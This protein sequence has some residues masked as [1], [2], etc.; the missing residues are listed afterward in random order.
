M[1]FDPLPIPGAYLVRLSPYKDERGEFS[2]IYCANEFRIPY[3]N[4]PLL[5]INHS[6][7]RER[8]T[9]RGM[10][11]QHPPQSEVKII[12]CLRGRV[13]D[14]MVDLREGSPTF[15]K[16]H[17]VELTPGAYTEVF[18]PEGCAHGF[19]TLEDDSELLYFH[20]AFYNRE[21]EGGVCYDD[22]R[23]G[24]HWPLPVKNVSPKDQ[25]YPKLD[26]KFTG[27]PGIEIQL[28]P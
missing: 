25:S 21:K 20:T 10:H 24:I 28:E 14:V 19:Q 9:V 1:D 26:A 16:W 5:Q 12:R 8:G 6:V 4:K 22:A 17:A 18:I 13:Y 15:L 3:L 27:L 7:N 11:F 23:I 2:R